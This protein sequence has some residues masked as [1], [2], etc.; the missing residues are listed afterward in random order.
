MAVLMGKCAASQIIQ[1]MKIDNNTFGYFLFTDIP[2]D[3]LAWGFHNNDP[4]VILLLYLLA[5]LNNNG[6]Y[7][8]YLKII[9]NHDET[10]GFVVVI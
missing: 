10:F 3:Y 6:I 1:A 9:D 5:V 7:M 4:N 8:A 2:P